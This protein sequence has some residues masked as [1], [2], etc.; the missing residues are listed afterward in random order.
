MGA[1]LRRRL[2]FL[3]GLAFRLVALLSVALLPLGLISIVQTLNLTRQAAV[4][5][6]Q[7]LLGRTETVAAA[8]RSIM[9]G[10][11][12]TAA[13][14]GAIVLQNRNDMAECS[15]TLASLIE[16]NA[17][18]TFAGF[19]QLD[20]SV[21]CASI[22]VPD[23]RMLGSDAY[24]SFIESPRMRFVALE[25]G[26]VTGRKVVAL[27]WPLRDGDTLLGYVA[28]SVARDSFRPET[29][30]PEMVGAQAITVNGVGQILAADLP[31]DEAA[32]LLPRDLSQWS[33]SGQERQ[34]IRATARNGETRIFTIVP[35]IPNLAYTIGTWAP[36]AAATGGWLTAASAILFP[37]VMWIVSLTVAYFAVFRLVVR[38]IR[39]LRGQMRRFALGNREAP[40]EV[41]TA[42]P[43]EIQDVSQT[44]HNLARILIR[45]EEALERSLGEKT[46][47]L[48]EVHHRV[49]NNLQLIAS[50][51]SMQGRLLDDP[52]AKQVLRSIQDRVASLA[53]IYRNLYQAE[54]LVA[55]QADQ[56]MADILN[57][58]AN[59]AVA[60]G[61][62]LHISTDLVPMPLIPDQ[63]VPLSLLAT[64]A[65]TNAVKYAAPPGIGLAPFV[66]VRLSQPEPGQGELVVENSIGVEGVHDPDSTG[67][68]SQLIEAFAMQLDSEAVTGPSEDGSIWRLVLR[69]D[70]DSRVELRPEDDRA[71]VL[72]SA[73]RGRR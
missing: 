60:P 1:A 32:Q 33:L 29:H 47:L 73:H 39:T 54:H 4:G 46:V 44:F 27:T 64:E 19:V 26:T 2:A 42:A 62:K 70:I 68:G 66:R 48:K 6:E 72:T 15:S 52:G 55:V 67:L 63:A 9:Q 37:L 30:W 7:S 31:G 24:Q 56:L 49:K 16:A 41:L 8:E 3:D 5:M 12:G 11:I 36:S 50:I 10:S 14:I 71:A 22:P 61:S 51:I 65:L 21:P 69:F 25:R 34:V 45:D 35:S 18:F 58:M 23:Y 13:A 28:L 59:A 57:G 38:H 53:A 43:A 40:P 17:L 20:G